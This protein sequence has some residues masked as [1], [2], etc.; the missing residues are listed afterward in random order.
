[1]IEVADTD[2][3]RKISESEFIKVMQSAGGKDGGKD[4]KLM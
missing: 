4:P 1:M 2:G 3:D